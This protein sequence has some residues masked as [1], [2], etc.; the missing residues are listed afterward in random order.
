MENLSKK[1]LNYCLFLLSRQSYSRRQIMDKLKR[2]KYPAAVMNETLSKLVEWKYL[3]DHAFA[4]QFA[5]ARLR[6]KPRSARLL[7]RE[8]QEKGITR[9]EAREVAGSVL[10][11]LG[12]D[13]ETLAQQA[14][15]KKLGGYLKIERVKGAT[16]AQNFLLRQG[17][18]YEIAAKLVKRYWGQKDL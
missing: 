9:E 14:L 2:K 12:L 15:E 16:R 3:D 7:V 1:A 8:L 17:F 4:V 10:E 11:Q 18:S 5:R 13:E 6:S